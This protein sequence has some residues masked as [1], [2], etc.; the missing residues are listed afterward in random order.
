VNDEVITFFR[1]KG[2]QWELN[3]PY[4]SAQNGVAERMNRTI[5]DKTGCMLRG[6]NL[7]KTFWIEAAL[8]AVYLINRSPT[9]A[10]EGNKVP[11]EVWY[12]SHPNLKRLRKFGCVAFVKKI[13]SEIDNKMESRSKK[14]ILLGFCPNGYRLWSLSE[15]KV[16]LAC[17]VVFDESRTSFEGELGNEIIRVSEEEQIRGNEEAGS[18]EDEPNIGER[19]S[20]E[21]TGSSPH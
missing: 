19:N 3:I 8:K 21:E 15:R 11:A 4:S 17:D 9:K 12:G 1:E 16:I 6:S 7:K 5:K 10:I 14:C 2:I 13:M 18:G 20:Q